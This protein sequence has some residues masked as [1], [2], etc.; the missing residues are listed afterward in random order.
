MSCLI[1]ENIN[2]LFITIERKNGQV[3]IFNG[4]EFILDTDKRFL[5][6][7]QIY[8]WIT[9]NKYNHEYIIAL[10]ETYIKKYENFV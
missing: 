10:A 7:S 1:N 4:K 6:I 3:N 9:Q 5:D 2:D 8:S